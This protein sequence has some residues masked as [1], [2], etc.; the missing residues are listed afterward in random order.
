MPYWV[1]HLLGLIGE[2]LDMSKIEY[3]DVGLNETVFSV[4]E[5]LITVLDIIRTDAQRKEQLLDW[6]CCVDND[7]VSGD[8]MRVQQ[9]LL[10]LLSNAVKYTQSGGRISLRAEEKISSRR[11]VGCF[12]FT[13]EDNDLNREIAGEL[14]NMAGLETACACDGRQAVDLFASNPPGT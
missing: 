6:N 1:D 11:G 8:S 5:T 9:I 12:E 7:L 13:V 3:G 10:N 2:V 14:L 4:K